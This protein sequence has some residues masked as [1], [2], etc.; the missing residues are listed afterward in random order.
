MSYELDL[1]KINA[2]LE[3]VNGNLQTHS[4][5]RE[6]VKVRLSEVEQLIAAA[7]LGNG[8]SFAGGF[9]A[10]PSFGAMT[11]QAVAD[12]QNPGFD[13]VVA[14]NQGMARVKLEGLAIRAA[15]TGEGWGTSDDGTV[16]LDPARGGFVGDPLRNPWLL[17]ALNH[18]PFSRD[19]NTWVQMEST[20]APSEQILQGAMKAHW[21]WTGTLKETPIITVAI[22]GTIARQ[23]LAD[24]PAL[25]RFI[26]TQGRG[27]TRIHSEELLVNGGTGAYSESRMEGLLEQS[28]VMVPTLGGNAVDVV[29]ESAVTMEINGFMPRL[30]VVHPL[31]WHRVAITKTD[32]EGEYLFAPPTQPMSPRWWSLP[33]VKTPAL[34]QGT[35]LVIDTDYVD[36]LDRMLP[37]TAVS[38]Q[39]QDY[40]V[41]NLAAVLT[42][43]RFGLEVRHTGAVFQVDV[44]PSS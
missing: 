22:W 6:E 29:G 32:T 40:F 18:R 27:R 43:L 12:G 38:T 13:S 44:S 11:M 24:Q 9:G 23:L 19:S 21:D 3:K 26:D 17:T 34:P 20:G 30:V 15:L 7:N 14:G 2:A 36:V 42:E 39:H 5:E 37:V 25:Q 8:G 4:A 35:A 33:I 16:P 10:G 31:D 1:T 28:T 41:R